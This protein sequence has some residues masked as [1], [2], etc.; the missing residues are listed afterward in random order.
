MPEKVRCDAATK[1]VRLTMAKDH[2]LKVGDRVRMF[3]EDR[4][5]EQEVAAII[6]AKSFE[7]SGISNDP[8]HIFV[9]GKEVNDF[10][11]V[12]YDRIFTTGISAIQQLSKEVDKLKVTAA[13]VVELEQK[14][15]KV[16]T[17]E[18]ELTELKK[19]VARLVEGQKGNRP[20]AAVPAVPAAPG[21]SI[22]VNR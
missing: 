7:I 18:N 21:A 20:V 2:E 3:V 11:S 13:R 4:K 6:D 12:E 19:V 17:L 16:D 5:V 15:A 22:E 8:E 10:L 14:A 9:Y 1:T